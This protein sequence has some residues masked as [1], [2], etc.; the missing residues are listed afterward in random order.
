M[1]RHDTKRLALLLLA[2]L[3]LRLAGAWWWQSRQPDDSPFLFGDSASY[4]VLAQTIAAGEPYRY[5]SEDA[6]VFRAPGYPILLVPVFLV[7]GPQPPILWGRALSAVFGTATVAGVWWLARRLFGDR[8]GWFAGVIAAIYPG[9]VVVSWL[10]LSEA[11]FGALM[12]LQLVLWTVAWQADSPGRATGFA[13][14]AGLAA[15]AAALVRPSWLLFTPGAVLL[16]LTFGCPRRRHLGI[17]LALLSGGC[18]VMGPWWVRNARVTGHFVP[19]TLQVG[20]SLY[21]GLHEGATGASNMDFVADFVANERWADRYR[22]ETPEPFEYRLDRSFRRASLHWAANHR[23]EVVRLAAIKF[24]R[25]WNVW[26]NE[27]SLSHWPVRLAVLASY[28]P[29]LV[30]GLIGAGRSVRLGWP[31]CAVLAAGGLLH[32]IAHDLRQFDSLS[33]AGH[34]GADRPGGGRDGHMVLGEGKAVEGVSST[35]T[36]SEGRRTTMEG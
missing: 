26:P 11:P 24:A 9:S 28:L 2:A 25:M 36:A 17:G 16:G 30:L 33:A 3:A 20:A 4:W 27:P 15:G 19:T 23:Q 12:I 13:L 6:K 14:A 31:L 34:A 7:A 5:G 32:G 8:A 29:V 35:A 10:V 21:D 18:L 1:R 22:P